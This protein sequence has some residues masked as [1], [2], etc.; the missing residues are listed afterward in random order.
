M[1]A[2]QQPGAESGVLPRCF[3]MECTPPRVRKE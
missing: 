1:M 2:S 3:W